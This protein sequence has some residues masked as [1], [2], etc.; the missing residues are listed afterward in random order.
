MKLKFRTAVSLVAC[1]ASTYLGPLPSWGR[2]V[3]NFDSN[4]KTDW[5]DFSFG[6]GQSTVANGRFTFQIPA[7]GQ[8]IFFASTKKSETFTLQDGRTIEF[9]VDLVSGNSKDSFAILSW[10]PTSASVS[11]LAGYSVAKSTTDILVTKG[12]NKYFYNE[13]PTPEIKNDNVTLVLSLTASGTSVIINTKVLDKDNNNAVLFDKTFVDTPAADI[14]SD[15]TDSPAAAYLGAGNFVLMEY[16][17]FDASGPDVY[18]VVLDNAQA[19]VLDHATLDDFNDNTKS[20]WQDF[21]FGVGQSTEANGQFKFE[22]PAAGQA[23]F[24]A[25]TKTSQT[26]EVSDGQKLELSVDLIS[27]N[28]KDSFAILSW[29][30]TTASVSA[31]AGYSIAKSTTDILV[32]KGINKY[33]YNENPT[34]AIKNENVTLVLTLTGQGSNV[35]IETKVLDKDNNN[36]VLF[37]KTFID[38][39]AADI[40]SDGKDDPAAPY[41][42]R[43]NFVLMEYEDFD[44]GGPEVYEVILDNARVAA[45]PT[46]GNTPPVWTEIQPED[47]ANFLPASTTISFKVT[48]DKALVDGAITLSLNGTTYTSTNGL[49]LGGSP[50]AR[51]GTWTGLLPDTNYEA[52][53]RVV[54]ADGVTNATTRY[55]D[56]FQ[57]SRYVIE[58]E[59]YNFGSGQF[60]D[61]PAPAGYRGQVG[62]AEVDFHDSRVTGDNFPYRSDDPVGTKVTLDFARQKFSAA[63]GA[64]SDIFDYDIGEMAAGDSVNYT[65]TFPAGSYEVYLRESLFNVLHGEALLELVTSDPTQPNQ[66]TTVLGSFLGFNSGSKFRN[67]PLTDALG[68]SKVVVKL[69]G[70]QTLRLRQVTPEPDDGDIFQ[71]YL[72]FIPSEAVGKQRAAVSS[73]TP[74]A[75]SVLESLFPVI[76]ATLQNHDTSVKTN[77]IVLQVNGTVVAPALTN[78]TTETTVTYK[79]SPLPAS[80]STNDVQLVFSDNEDVLQT[81][82]WSFVLTYK[83]LLASNRRAGPGTDPGFN[84][85]VVQAPQGTEGLENSLGRAEDQLSANSK[86]PAFYSTNDIVSV[87]NF[88]DKG[89]DSTDGY[90]PG[91]A[92]IPGLQPDVNGTDDIAM[93]V[94]TYLELT[95]GIHRFGVRCDDGYKLV[96]GTSLTDNTTPALAFHNGG[97]ADETVDFMVPQTGLYPF[98]LVW[99]E[100]G[101][102]AHVEWFSVNLDTEEKTLINDL[103]VPAAVKAFVSVPASAEIQVE[104]I[105]KITDP[106]TASGSATIDTAAQTITIPIVGT[107][108]FFRLRQSGARAVITGFKI[109]GTNLVLTYTLAPL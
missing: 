64:A 79:L 27:G 31:L 33:F 1:L 22:I 102:A 84:V 23:L 50:T 92:L 63:G 25:S 85:H 10:I 82:R 95:A 45:P 94:K 57:S 19:F 99:Y 41:L 67:V 55:F 103:S 51:T 28:G 3:D 71:N 100:R 4:T 56:T 81:N 14:L 49:V 2:V 48:D 96:A 91:D 30:P 34:P 59:D 104:S 7:A 15:G 76:T 21:S 106:F 18:E 80:N 37:D 107:S 109:V 108:G 52:T 74:A 105:S 5:E 87:I 40:L 43:G 9:R 101:G 58:A 20:D 68:Q 65:R 13:N 97:P 62:V 8:A 32:T 53:F 78:T 98:R 46:T 66:T 36:A 39:P 90:F 73:V 29:I 88:S 89:P 86:I 16:E 75:G 12:I 38:T 61:N 6:A 17:D 44:A 77:T 72:I 83:S 93:E 70:K 26:Y 35:I 47:F 24:F 69:S 42:G 54:D 11:S 60:I